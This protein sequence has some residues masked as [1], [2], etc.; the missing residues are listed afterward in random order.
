MH[1]PLEDHWRDVK[2][3]IWYLK[4]TTDYGIRINQSIRL[5]LSMFSYVDYAGNL[6][7]RSSTTDCIFFL[8]LIQL[9]GHKKTIARLSSEAEYW[10]VASA[11]DY[12]T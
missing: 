2:R 12:T 7:A 4:S 3:L 8:G 5:N 9:F 1:A 6:S 11:V 10:A